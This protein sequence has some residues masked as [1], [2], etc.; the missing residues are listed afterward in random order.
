MAAVDKSTGRKLVGHERK[1]TNL[2][3]VVI[4][5]GTEDDDLLS[6]PQYAGDDVMI[7]LLG[8]CTCF[9]QFRLLRF[10]L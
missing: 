6:R 7:K 9:T 10:G 5:G 4:S 8:C 1:H 2:Q 3:F